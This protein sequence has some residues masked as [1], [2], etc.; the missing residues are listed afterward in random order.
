VLANQSTANTYFD[1]I[2]PRDGVPG[3]TFDLAL[4]RYENHQLET[5]RKPGEYD[6]VCFRGLQTEYGPTRSALY[7]SVE[8]ML[9]EKLNSI[10]GPIHHITTVIDPS[11]NSA[12]NIIRSI[13]KAR[14]IATTRMHAAI[15]ALAN[16]R[17]VVAVDQI[18]GGAKV[19]S[20]LE[21]IEW[22]LVFK[23]DIID[24]ATL[25]AAF[26]RAKS[27]DIIATVERCRREAIDRSKDALNKSIKL[28]TSGI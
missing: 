9:L 17:P 12:E 19:S 14:L 24:K 4:A 7:Q 5:A 11:A 27:M 8:R 3:A 2:L 25:D 22:P 13:G 6:A 10:G 18:P 15:Y 1:Q 23:A 26:E 21:T 20:M 16:H 28:I